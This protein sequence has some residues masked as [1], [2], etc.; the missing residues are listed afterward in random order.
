M[1][2][3]RL[4]YFVAVAEERHFARAAGRLHI[5]APSLSQ[6]IR[7]LERDLHAVLFDRGPREVQLTP[8]GQVL[9][10]HARRPAGSSERARDEVRLAKEDTG[11]RRLTLRLATGA[12]YVLGQELRELQDRAP[13]LEVTAANPRSSWT[14]RRVSRSSRGGHPSRVDRRPR[15]PVT[16]G[17]AHCAVSGTRR[18]DSHSRCSAHRPS[19]ANRSTRTPSHSSRA[20]APGLRERTLQ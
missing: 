8:A 14:A 12:Q 2:L 13:H 11:H 5:A 16:A 17:R 6:Q 20:G 15:G 3:R 1:E 7:A 4:R 19:G 10:A 18:C 9:L